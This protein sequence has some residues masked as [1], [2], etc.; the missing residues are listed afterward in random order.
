M[1]SFSKSKAEVILVFEHH[2]I[3]PDEKSSK[4]QLW[5]DEF[6]LMWQLFIMRFSYFMEDKLSALLF[7]LHILIY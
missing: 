7:F 6:W 4:Q 2:T 1:L 5:I 3:V